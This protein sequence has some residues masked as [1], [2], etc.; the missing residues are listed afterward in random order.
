MPWLLPVA[1]IIGSTDG[2][3]ALVEK[4]KIE[5]VPLGFI[6]GRSFSNSIIIC[7]EAENLTKE[8]IQLLIGRVGEGSQLWLNGDL[9]QRDMVVFEKS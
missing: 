1:D 6:R 5:A 9:R 2:L 8:Q 4:D 3:Y 7:S